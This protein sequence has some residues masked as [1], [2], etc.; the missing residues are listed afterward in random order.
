MA[1][2]CIEVAGWC[3]VGT[4]VEPVFDYDTGQWQW[5]VVEDDD[6]IQVIDVI[7]SP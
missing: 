5:F 2:D 1:D 3:E 4:K 7:E 6:G